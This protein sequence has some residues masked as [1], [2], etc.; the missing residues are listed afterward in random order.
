MRRAIAR[1]ERERV[2]ADLPTRVQQLIEA[3]EAEHRARIA[4]LTDGAGYPRSGAQRTFAE[5]LSGHLQDGK[6][7]IR[8]AT[9]LAATEAAKTLH[10]GYIVSAWR[11]T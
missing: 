7:V 1:I 11:S 10:G 5:Y 8:A 3:L 2:A 6:R 4:W 9:T